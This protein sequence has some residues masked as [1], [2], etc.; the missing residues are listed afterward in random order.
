MIKREVRQYLPEII[1]DYGSVAD[2]TLEPLYFCSENI[3]KQ[4]YAS[5]VNTR[6][7]L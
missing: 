6:V 1:P 3:R 5:T 2:V 4:I 7:G